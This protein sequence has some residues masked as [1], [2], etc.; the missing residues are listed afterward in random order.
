M[1]PA[2]PTGRDPEERTADAAV[3][4][5]R[6]ALERLFEFLDSEMPD[7]DCRRLKEHIAACQACHDAVDAE[8]HVRELLR[9]SCT[10]SAP[11]ALRVRVITQIL[12]RRSRS[13]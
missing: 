10:E 1:R 11:S 3:C 2:Y 9:R 13:T 8:Q 12:V 7:S 5:C 6:E 4:D